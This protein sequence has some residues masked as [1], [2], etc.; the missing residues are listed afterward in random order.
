MVG[1]TSRGLGACVLPFRTYCPGEVVTVTLRKGP[2]GPSAPS[3][4]LD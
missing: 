1:Y 4:S 2:P 3:L